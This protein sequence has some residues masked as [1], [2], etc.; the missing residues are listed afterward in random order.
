MHL[1]TF[2][3]ADYYADPPDPTAC[4]RLQSVV[5]L[6]LARRHVEAKVWEKAIIGRL[7]SF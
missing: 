4:F 6:T 2:T 3:Q 5:Q 1:S 7:A